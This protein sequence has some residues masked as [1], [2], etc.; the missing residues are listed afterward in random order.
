MGFAGAGGG[1][2]TTET[3]TPDEWLPLQ[4]DVVRAH[5]EAADITLQGFLDYGVAVAPG[6]LRVDRVAYAE[7]PPGEP[8]FTLGAVLCPA[9]STPLG[10][11]AGATA[12]PLR[13]PK[14]R[15]IFFVR[16]F[17]LRQLV[18]VVLA[19]GPPSVWCPECA[20][21]RRLAK[22]VC[23]DC[24]RIGNFCICGRPLGDIQK[25]PCRNPLGPPASASGALRVP[26]SPR[27]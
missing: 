6:H 3:L 4:H 10:I 14:W 27:A 8:P 11:R 18:R 22:A 1:L 25:L 13:R 26:S 20:R 24:V 5:D 2:R 12:P 17:S 9:V 16:A 21:Q 7:V 19:G 23:V 15:C